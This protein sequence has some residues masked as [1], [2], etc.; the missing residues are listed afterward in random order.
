MK[1]S[2]KRLR[3]FFV[4]A[5][6]LSSKSPFDA[7]LSREISFAGS[8]MKVSL[9]RLR[10]FFVAAR[11]LLRYFDFCFIKSSYR[12]D[13]ERSRSTIFFRASTVKSISS[14]VFSAESVN[15]KEPCAIS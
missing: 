13:M 10:D 15:R 8:L 12:G 2:L 7:F 9:K 14:F 4:A 11:R 5:R 3:D 1:V 6:R